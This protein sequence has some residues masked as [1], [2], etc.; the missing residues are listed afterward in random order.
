MA[1]TEIEH[2]VVPSLLDRL[3]DEEPQVSLD[4]QVSREDSER[5]FRRSVERDVESLFNTRRTM[6]PAPE[7]L[8]ELRHSV[9]DYGL[10]DST[11]IPVGT[12]TGRER[13]I[14]GLRDAIT[15]FEPRMAEPSVRLLDADQVRA[16]QMRFEVAAILLMDRAREQVVFD[17]VLE[18]ASG[19][20][21]VHGSATPAA[22][23]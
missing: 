2:I 22:G 7:G 12:K 14:A 20:Y 9:Y 13:L 15:R 18:V 1:R 4:P 19:E 17:T 21:D 3:T 11:G 16:P 23:A 10:L 8:T 5:R 6:A